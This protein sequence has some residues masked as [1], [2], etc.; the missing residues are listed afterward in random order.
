VDLWWF[1]VTPQ[2]SQRFEVIFVFIEKVKGEGGKGHHGW[3]CGG[4]T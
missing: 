2:R 3:I 1:H 4:S